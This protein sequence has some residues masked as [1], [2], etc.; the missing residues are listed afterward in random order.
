VNATPPQTPRFSIAE[1]G[2]LVGIVTAVTSALYAGW[3]VIAMPVLRAVA[4]Q[5][6]KSE[7]SAIDH[8][9]EAVKTLTRQYAELF[10]ALDD[11]KQDVKAGRD[12]QRELRDLIIEVLGKEP[13]RRRYDR[14]NYDD[15]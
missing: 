11:V 3:R 14:G 1:W 4:R 7:L 13:G 6:L 5:V 10:G 9:G 2:I 15:T 8:T 12:E